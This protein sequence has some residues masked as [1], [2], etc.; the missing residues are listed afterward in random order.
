MGRKKNI[1][2]RNGFTLVEILIVLAIIGILAAISYTMYQSYFQTAFQSEVISKMKELQLEQSSRFAM[3]GTYACKID[4]LPSIASEGDEN[5]YVLN[6]DKVG[7]RRFTMSIYDS[8]CT[9]SGSDAHY[10]IKAENNPSDN[11]WKVKW[12]LKCGIS[13][14]NK[15]EPEQVQGSESVL[16]SIF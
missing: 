9:E 4:K 11:K 16:N 6:N 14:T 13:V 5:K 10:I 7:K 1:F 15:C 8:N 3:N 2:A 12:E